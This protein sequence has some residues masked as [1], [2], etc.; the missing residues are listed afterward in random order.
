MRV[1]NSCRSIP[2]LMLLLAAILLVILPSIV[3]GAFKPEFRPT[4]EIGKTSASIDV[5]GQLNDPGWISAARVDNFVERNPGDN[6]EPEV[7]TEVFATY[8]DHNFYVAFVCYDDPKAIRATMCQRDQLGPDDIAGVLIDP[9]ANASWSYQLFVN[10]YGIQEDALWTPIAGDNGGYDLIWES[11]AAV[12]DSGYQVEIALP[13]ASMR[14]PN[15][16]V[17]TWKVNFWRNRPR[18]AYKQYTWA[19]NDRNEQCFPCQFGTI[20]GISSVRPG[21]GIG[22]MPTMV[23]HQSG[24]ISD[25]RNPDS[26]F[27][28]ADPKGEFSLG[29]K[30]AI[31]SDVTVEAT[32]N[33][34][35]SQIEADAAQIDVNSTVSL[36]YPERR[37]F[38]Q[39]GSD[40]FRTL[41][42][43]FYTRTVNDPQ[44]A[45]KLTARMGNTTL[46]Y[47]GARD[48]NSPYMIPLEE[49]SILLNTGKSTIN[50]LRG[51]RSFGSDSRFGILLSDRRFEH[52][53]S[54]TVAA[55]DGD[56]RLS[57]NYSLTGQYIITH[58]AEPQDSA[59]TARFGNYGFDGDKH[60][61]AFD[62]ESYT[63]TAFIQQFRREARHWGFV[64]D[65]NQVSPTYRTEV[66]Y[67]PVMGHRTLSLNSNY[68]FYPKNSAFS[69][70]SPGFFT[71]RRWKFD[72]GAR[73][74]SN[75]FAGLDAQFRKAQTSISVNAGS[76]TE[77]YRSTEFA[78]LWEVS[79]NLN[80]RI[81]N[82]IGLGGGF[83]RGVNIAYFA[84][85]KGNMTS[86]FASFNLKPIDRLVIQ[87]SI[88]FA[89]STDRN[90]DMEF[91][92]GYITRTRVLYQ[93]NR[94]LSFRFVVQYDD[95][96][97]AWE[98]DPL[99]TYRL[100]PFSVLY[101]GSSN[102]YYDLA[103]SVNSPSQWRLAERQFFMKIQYLFQ[104]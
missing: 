39:E 17:Q 11:A 56:I 103:P 65:Y 23:A 97:R 63:G 102:D 12:T 40:I 43:S 2:G 72:D 52:D 38:F 98:I 22:I 44:V 47:V 79:L 58:T 29:G 92:S 90:T 81:N 59:S 96:S 95:F 70:I 32:I 93:A 67:D 28:N 9:Y 91:Y 66:G 51:L 76:N 77:L 18:E 7:R 20:T 19:A 89:K 85:A 99:M 25:L 4:L 30:Y 13:F 73:R 80:S 75:F 61:I 26:P 21:K 46:G 83:S 53:G 55:V 104:T 41:F 27:R 45:A 57:K 36:M 35:F 86:Y 49:S 78:G 6:T 15:Q 68:T 48:M 87:P 74:Y 82:K 5:D 100:S 101:L 54:G 31:N 50:V 62:G 64:I 24:R 16:D 71:S 1:A 88:N 10:S 94:E 69:R 14:F 42:N 8:D 84:F 33:P 3:L 60:T 34:D 37:P